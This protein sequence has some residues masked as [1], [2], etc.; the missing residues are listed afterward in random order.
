M[1]ELLVCCNLSIIFQYFSL[2][3]WCLGCSKFKIKVRSKALPGFQIIHYNILTNNKTSSSGP[4]GFCQLAK[5]MPRVRIEL[6][7]F[8][9]WDWRAAYCAIEA[10]KTRGKGPKMVGGTTIFAPNCQLSGSIGSHNDKLVLRLTTVF[11][12]L[13]MHQIN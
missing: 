13:I 11:E 8:R 2:W 10:L 5:L 3:F 4:H 6:T 12:Q 1:N 9:I 7:T